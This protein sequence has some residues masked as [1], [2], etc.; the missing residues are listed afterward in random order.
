M[1]ATIKRV[2]TKKVIT[3]ALV[4]ILG[5]V[6]VAMPPAA[7]DA[8]ATAGAIVLGAEPSASCGE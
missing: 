8:L 6:G 1:L 3:A 2:A 5:A 4:V 7:V